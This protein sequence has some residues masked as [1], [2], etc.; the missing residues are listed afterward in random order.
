MLAIANTELTNLDIAL[1]HIDFL[2]LVKSDKQAG[3]PVN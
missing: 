1:I 2:L 3:I